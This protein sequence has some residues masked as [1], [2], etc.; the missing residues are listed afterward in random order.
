MNYLTKVISAHVI[1]IFIVASSIAYLENNDLILSLKIGV[2][3]VLGCT[4]FGI[5]SFVLLCALFSED[6]NKQNKG[7]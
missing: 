1:L 6:N 3:A 7:I 5:G 4:A 2:I